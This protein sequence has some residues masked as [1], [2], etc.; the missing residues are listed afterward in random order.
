MSNADAWKRYK[1]QSDAIN[2]VLHPEYQAVFK[3]AMEAA[4]ALRRC[5]LHDHS[6]SEWAQPAF[7]GVLD[8]IHE[9]SRPTPVAEGEPRAG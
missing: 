2:L 8:A 7:E 6:Q 9:A 5:I 4:D 3:A 1:A